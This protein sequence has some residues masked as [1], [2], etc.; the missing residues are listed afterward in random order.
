[1]AENADLQEAE[2]RFLRAQKALEDFTQEN[3]RLT[4]AGSEFVNE[5]NALELSRRLAAI[6]SEY[7][8]AG[9]AWAALL[10]KQM[11]TR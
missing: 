4:L 7:D 10:E 8:A 1:M 2:D 11:V 3:I 9:E 6:R 5:S